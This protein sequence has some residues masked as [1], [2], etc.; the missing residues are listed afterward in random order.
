[1]DN[2]ARNLA[3]S[4]KAISVALCAT[5][6]FLVGAVHPE[7]SSADDF[8]PYI[9]NTVPIS[10]HVTKLVLPKTMPNVLFAL[11][12]NDGPPKSSNKVGLYVFDTSDAINPKQI[13]YLSV[14]S[15]VGMEL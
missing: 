7:I 11:V 10:G 5:A 6:L 3:V 4:F 9:I 2:V 14:T 15:P 1:M 13:S 8:Y 12:Q